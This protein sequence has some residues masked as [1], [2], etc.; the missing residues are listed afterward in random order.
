M[1]IYRFLLPLALASTSLASALAAEADAD[2]AAV[3]AERRGCFSC[4]DLR[5]PRIGPSFQAIATTH[6]GDPRAEARLMDKIE[7]GGRGHWGEEHNMSP[8][9][10]LR[11]GEART[12]V[13]W[14]LEQ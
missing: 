3:L 2:P 12:L 11:P 1:R 5:E 7:T 8:Q 14:V 4:H 10:Q 6:R 13:R 9:F